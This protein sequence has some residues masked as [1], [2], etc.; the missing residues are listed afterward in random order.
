MNSDGRQPSASTKGV[1]NSREPQNFDQAVEGL[2]HQLWRNADENALVTG[3]IAL[4]GLGTASAELIAYAKQVAA[5]HGAILNMHQSYNDADRDAVRRMFGTDPIIG[6]ERLGVLDEG[7]LLGHANLL[8]DR[9]VAALVRSGAGISWA[10]AASMMWGH[11]S[12]LESR[13]A[14]VWT[15][16]GSVGLGSDSGNWSNSFDLF[17]Q[18]TLSIFVSRTIRR[19]RGALGVADVLRIATVGGAKAVGLEDRVGSLIPGKRADIVIHSPRT[20][21]LVPAADPLR[22]LI[23]SSGSKSVDTVIVDGTVVLRAGKLTTVD[24]ADAFDKVNSAA[25]AMFERVGYTVR[26]D[27]PQ[28]V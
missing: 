8:T 14:E 9:E 12:A 3:S 25:R 11:Q 28:R 16:G 22:N 7:L 2:G 17:R 6:L 21:E 10:P 13:H 5:K 4:R 20:P 19:D 24:E 18:A 27:R 26:R 23:Y 15:S 1:V